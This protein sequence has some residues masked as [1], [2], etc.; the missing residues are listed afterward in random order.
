MSSITSTMDWSRLVSWWLFLAP[1][2][3]SLA[4]CETENGYM[5]GDEA[6][7]RLV[8]Y[9]SALVKLL[10]SAGPTGYSA[11][12]PAKISVDCL[13]LGFWVEGGDETTNQRA[14]GVVVKPR[15][16]VLQ[17]CHSARIFKCI[18][19]NLFFTCTTVFYCLSLRWLPANHRV[20]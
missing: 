3:P 19:F 8:A 17:V 12:A 6:H 13:L 9:A 18:L 5:R 11:P 16:A 4:G 2:P 15:P 20:S 14:H 10:Y 1:R 7:A